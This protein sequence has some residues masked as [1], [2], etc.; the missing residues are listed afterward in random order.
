MD[1]EV[2]LVLD[3]SNSLSAATKSHVPG[4]FNGLPCEVVQVHRLESHW[5]FVVFY[6]EASWDNCSP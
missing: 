2:Y 5:Y 1:T 4:K 6:T 3:P